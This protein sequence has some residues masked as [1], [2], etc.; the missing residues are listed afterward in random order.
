MTVLKGCVVLS[1]GMGSSPQATKVSALAAVADA[2]GWR[3]LRPDYR[4]LDMQGLAAA[5]APRLARLIEAIPGDGPCVLVGSS[6]GAFISGLASLQRPVGGLFLLATPPLIPDYAHPF[7]MREGVPACFVHG[8]RDD[9]CPVEAVFNIARPY[10]AELLLLD[11]DHRLSAKVEIIATC[12]DRFLAR[13]D[14]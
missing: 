13:L 12:F 2:H 9:L 10:R 14:A 7:A 4:D 1:H 6:F 5:A 11:D 8:W 3:T